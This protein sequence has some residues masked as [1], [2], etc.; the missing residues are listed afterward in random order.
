MLELTDN[1]FDAEVIK[2]NQLVVV[3][4]WA[5]WC[6]PCRMMA[7]AFESLAIKNPNVKFAKMNVDDNS[8]TPTKYRVASIP[9]VIAF[10]D[11][12]IKDMSVG[13]LPETEL[14]KF[15]DRNK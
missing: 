2:S 14:Q 11:G 12:N 1:N 7:P 5:S 3:D 8:Q 15:V 9:T 13:A 4:F 10:K 6:G